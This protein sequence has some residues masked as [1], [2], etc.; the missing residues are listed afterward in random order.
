MSKLNLMAKVSNKMWEVG[1]RHMARL[2]AHSPELLM[3]LGVV[4][5][6]GAV[7]AAGVASRKIDEIVDEHV[8]ETN[9]IHEAFDEEK[10]LKDG[11]TYSKE[12]KQ[13][14]L[15]VTY[16]QTALKFAK[17]F[18]PTAILLTVGIGCFIGS[19]H[20]LNRKFLC[21]VA[22]YS[23]LEDSFNEYRGR[24]I[25]EYGEEKDYMF[26]NGLREQKQTIVDEE[27]KKKKEVVLSKDADIDGPAGSVYSKFFDSASRYWKKGNP[28]ANLLYAKS[29]EMEWNRVFKNRAE[30]GNG[31]VFLNEIYAAFD[32]PLTH[33]GSI[34]GWVWD[35][36]GD[37]YIDFGIFDDSKEANRR[38][39]NGYEDCILLDFNCQ[40]M[41][42]DKIA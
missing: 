30:R 22:A 33:T 37:N 9:R 27:G 35:D 24:V 29:Q 1:G 3:G 16:G 31:F 28:N 10:K 15:V 4:C 5:V 32:L 39:V 25:E 38:F 6:V 41:I 14:D 23:Q 13:K 19:H 11:S 34:C 2:S 36:D 26:R 42:S 21:V 12:N 8:D 40:G 7:V 18:A 20:I 17:L